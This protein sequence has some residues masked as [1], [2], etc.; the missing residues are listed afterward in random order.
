LSIDELKSGLEGVQIRDEVIL[1]IAFKRERALNVGCELF[2]RI[3]SRLFEN[4]L[5]IRR[6]TR[7]S[8][9]FVAEIGLCAA[10]G[11]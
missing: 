11:V 4:R 6:E 7:E 1:K 3:R 5:G 10:L 9:L 2:R 8:Y